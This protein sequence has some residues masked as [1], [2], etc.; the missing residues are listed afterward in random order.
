ME[1]LFTEILKIIVHRDSVSLLFAK[2]KRRGYNG[3]NCDMSK[4]P[5]R[6]TVK[7]II[8]GYKKNHAVE[9]TKCLGEK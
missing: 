5:N 9:Y 4:N 7:A 3:D 6:P 2:G 1:E 8:K